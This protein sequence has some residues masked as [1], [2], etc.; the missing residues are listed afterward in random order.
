MSKIRLGVI[1]VKDYI[2]MIQEIS[3]EYPKFS[4]FYFTCYDRNELLSII[5][6]H[7]SEVDMWLLSEHYDYLYIEKHKKANKPVFHIYSRSA[8]LYKTLCEVFYKENVKINDIS[9]DTIP[10][11]ELENCFERLHIQYNDKM[12]V[13]NA[14][15]ESSEEE[16]FHYHYSLWKEKKIKAV[17][18]C[19]WKVKNMLC[20]SGVPSYLVFPVQPCIR[21][22]FYNMMQTHDMQIVKDAQVAVQVFDFDMFTHTEK[23]YS[24]DEI[25]N[26]EIKLTQKLIA[27]TKKIQGSL[28]SIG[29]G[30]YFI[31]TTRGMLS[32][33][34]ANFTSTPLMEEFNAIDKKLIACGIGIGMSAYEAES[35]AA[36][37]LLNAKQYEEG[38]WMVVFDDKKITGPLG[39]KEQLTYS[40]FSEKLQQISQ[41]TSINISTLSKISAIMEKN[42]LTSINAQVLAQYMNILPRSARRI[43]SELEKGGLA[44]AIGEETPNL[45]GRPRKLYQINFKE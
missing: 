22:M 14:S 32:H 33:C 29:Q 16:L 43:I 26:E 8:S 38:S 5:E 9:F 42:R 28:K 13:C 37:A 12:Q 10:Y 27:Y 23:L 24:T 41:E 4:I 1:G 35:N 18:T 15:R 36:I 44:V 21:S 34:T 31:F 20:E 11:A 30:R 6:N 45:R 19:V 3:T 17:V 40:C 25:Y 2:K 39:K 7:E